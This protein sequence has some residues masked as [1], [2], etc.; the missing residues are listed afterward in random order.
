M[1]MIRNTDTVRDE[2]IWAM[3]QEDR[4]CE[5]RTMLR[6]VVEHVLLPSIQDLDPMHLIQV[7]MRAV[8]RDIQDWIGDA[9]TIDA[10]GLQAYLL[11]ALITAGGFEDVAA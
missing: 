11:A 2:L 10:R 5:P 9:E 6:E 4:Q 1:E 8:V 3:A 7:G